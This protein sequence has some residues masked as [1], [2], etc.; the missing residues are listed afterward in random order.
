MLMLMSSALLVKTAQDKW[1]RSSYA[2]ASAYVY[3][4]ACAQVKTSLYMYK[5]KNI[6]LC[7]NGCHYLLPVHMDL[8]VDRKALVTSL[9]CLRITAEWR[10]IFFHEI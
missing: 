6:P 3:A 5:C 1:V 8:L 10:S 7:G 9:V 2:S 4:C